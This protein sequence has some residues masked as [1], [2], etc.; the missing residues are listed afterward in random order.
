MEITS[1]GWLWSDLWH[2]WNDGMM[3]TL[4][5]IRG[6]A[7]PAPRRSAMSFRFRSTIQPEWFKQ[8]TLLHGTIWHKNRSTTVVPLR[9]FF[10]GRGFTTEKTFWQADM[11]RLAHSPCQLIQVWTDLKSLGW[12]YLEHV[13]TSGLPALGIVDYHGLS[14]PGMIF[15]YWRLNGGPLPHLKVWGC[16]KM[17]GCLKIG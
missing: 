7:L 3:L 1:F 12:R 9:F 15:L 11:E 10:G 2:H 16:L 13:G 17:R 6:I 8:S 5:L 14:L 4:R